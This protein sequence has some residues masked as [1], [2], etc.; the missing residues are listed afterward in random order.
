MVPVTTNQ[1][2]WKISP[3]IPL[4]SHIITIYYP[5]IN[6]ILTKYQPWSLWE[7]L[8]PSGPPSPPSRR[9]ALAHEHA[10]ARKPDGT[11]LQVRPKSWITT[12]KYCS[13]WIFIDSYGCSMDFLMVLDEFW[14]MLLWIFMDSRGGFGIV[15]GFYMNFEVDGCL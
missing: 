3:N 6:H 5:Y 7:V 4:W 12:V 13:R 11:Q 1:W 8:G 10:T 15:H 2:I 9:S 14:W